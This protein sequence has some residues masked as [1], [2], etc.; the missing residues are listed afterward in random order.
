MKKQT[1][2]WV[3][4]VEE[5]LYVL[6]LLELE[7]A[8]NHAAVLCQQILG[9]L[10]KAIWWELGLTPPMTHDLIE[11]WDTVNAQVRLEIDEVML[12][13]ITPYGTT[14]RYPKRLVSIED[15]TKAAVFCLDTAVKLK[16]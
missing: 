8:P 4:R 13:V 5:D 16:L 11:L 6:S 7:R 2:A 10:L 15:A 3:L 1:R 9:K 12:A 14:A